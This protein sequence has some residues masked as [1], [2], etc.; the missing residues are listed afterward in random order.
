M[1][2]VSGIWADTIEKNKK[3]YFIMYELRDYLN[4]INFSK[5]NLLDTPRHNLGEKISSLCY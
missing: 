4:A 2:Q 1:N 5:E 3:K